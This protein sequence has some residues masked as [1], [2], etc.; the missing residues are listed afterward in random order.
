MKRYFLIY[1][2]LLF[3]L[4]QKFCDIFIIIMKI[5]YEKYDLSNFILY[6][7]AGL[8]II[9]PVLLFFIIFSNLVFNQKNLFLLISCYILT[10][11]AFY[12]LNREIGVIM[13]SNFKLNK[14]T[15]FLNVGVFSWIDIILTIIRMIVLGILSIL[16]FRKL[17]RD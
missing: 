8:S 11:I 14:T 3:L 17:K 10:F 15:K 6:L 7:F 12:F 16:T 2:I 13:A 4:F 5:T 9:I 1:G